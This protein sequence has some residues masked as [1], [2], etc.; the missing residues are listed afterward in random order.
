MKRELRK[1]MEKEITD[2]QRRMW[3]D[4]DDVYYRE[5]DAERVKHELSLAQYRSQL[6]YVNNNRFYWRMWQCDIEYQMM[7]ITLYISLFGSTSAVSI[8]DIITHVW[9]WS[10]DMFLICHASLFDLEIDAWNWH[11]REQ[12]ADYSNENF[13]IWPWRTNCTSLIRLSLC[14]VVYALLRYVFACCMWGCIRVIF[15]TRWIVGLKSCGSTA[16]ISS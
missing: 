6:W 4:E 11:Y 9:S 1:K 14:G 12:D 2:F 8:T 13:P 5:L 7:R 3:E 15:L 10:G 16:V